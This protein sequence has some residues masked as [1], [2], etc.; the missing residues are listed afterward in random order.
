MPIKPP[1]AYDY[2]CHNCNHRFRQ[3]LW[4]RLLELRAP[5]FGICPKCGGIAAPLQY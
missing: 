2:Y 3:L 1:N 4:R 5:P